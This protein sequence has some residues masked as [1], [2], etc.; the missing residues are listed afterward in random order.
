MKAAI[1]FVL[2]VAAVNVGTMTGAISPIICFAVD[3]VAALVAYTAIVTAATN[4]YIN[5]L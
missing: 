5:K 1:A 2:I 4:K 3:L